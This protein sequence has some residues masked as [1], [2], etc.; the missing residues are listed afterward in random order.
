M[1]QAACLVTFIVW[2]S[3]IAPRQD[4]DWAADV[5]HGVTAEIG[6]DSMLVHHIR[7]FDWQDRDT[8]IHRYKTA[9][10]P[11]DS[12]TSVDLFTSVWGSPTIA[13]V[14]VTF[15][16]DAVR[17]LVFSAEIRREADEVFSSIVGFFKAFELVLIAAEELDIVKLR[18]DHRREDVSLFRLRLIH[19]QARELFLSYLHQGN[20]QAEQP[21]FY[22]TI[23]ANCTTVVFCPGATGRNRSAL[24][25]ADSGLGL[26]ARLSLWHRRP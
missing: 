20:A 1:R 12:I 9:S 24:R 11:L 4:R 19:A 22:N 21:K 6:A 3:G 14:L 15:G 23:N 7:D 5:A 25:Q 16:F 8:V 26:S 13:L 17:H 10:Y 18:T 2:W